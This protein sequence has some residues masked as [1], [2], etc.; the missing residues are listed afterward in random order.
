MSTSVLIVEKDLALM[1]TLRDALTGRGFQVEETTDGK[2]AP[3]LIRRNKPTCVVLA[4][5]LDAGQNG[6][7]ICKK[8]KSDDELKGVP[9]IIVGDPKGFA[10]HQKLKTRADQYLGKP[11][12]A[13]ALV[14]GVGGLVGFPAGAE[15]GFDL[16]DADGPAF[17]APPPE[18]ASSDADM[19]LV[20]SMFEE[21]S[22]EVAIDEVALESVSMSDEELDAPE[23]T[24]VGFL[25]V[26]PGTG[27]PAFQSSPSTHDNAEARDV[28]AKV[29]ELTGSLQ[30]ARGR[31]DELEA[32]VRELEGE[33][34]S[35][36]TE[37][38][39]ARA[40]GGKAD[41]KEVFALRDAANKKDKEILKLKNEL[42]AKEQEILELKEKENTLER[43]VSE[44]GDE[45]TARDAQLK[46]LQGK[47]D[48]QAAERKKLEQQLHQAKEEGRA[49]SAQLSTLQMDYDAGQQRLGELEGQTEGL[50][51]SLQE[52]EGG[53][54]QAESELAEARGELEALK[55]QL[56]ERGRELDE[57]RATA[58]Q[59]QGDLDSTRAQLT[60]QATSFADEISGLRQRLAETEAE[61]RKAEAKAR[62]AQQRLQGVLD[63]QERVRASLQN[64]M[65]TLAETPAEGGDVDVDELAEA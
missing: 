30:E 20:D 27:R 14:E 9:V 26:D 39:T 45:L 44:T 42:N 31:A 52:A 50:R 47:T 62:Q 46:T 28:R 61:T 12:D 19:A 21:K 5:D 38:E 54:Q 6:Y 55:A 22:A 49:A 48:Q 4:V 53:R 57:A 25:P 33:L 36:N 34:E 23:R 56:E 3:E 15:G 16:G 18:E 24:V 32:R 17:D 8:L 1:A 60:S 37:L 2:G 11:L 40:S 64:A 7:I 59:A 51:T 58:E 29:T 41:N 65:D 13:G 35:K 43:Q 10:Q 63:Q